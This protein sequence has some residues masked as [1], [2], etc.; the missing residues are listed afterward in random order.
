[1]TGTST[2]ST[3]T[4]PAGGRGR[5]LDCSPLDVA[6]VIPVVVV[7]D[8][9]RAV[10]LAKA[11]VAGGLPIIEV[12]L[13]SRAALEGVRAIAAE[14]PDIVLGVGT[15]VSTDQAEA[16]SAA[17]AQFLVSPGA[18]DR[19]LDAMTSTGVPFLAGTA[20]PSDVVRLLERG[21]TEAKLFPAEVVGGRS[22]LAALSGPFPQLRFC[23]TGGVT[24]DSA[25]DYLAMANVGCV[26]GTW[27]A[28]AG[29]QDA[30][31]WDA[32]T[33][34]ARRASELAAG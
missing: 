31:D 12:T 17:G 33:D 7:T 34:L 20:G 30:G 29:L 23:P 13:R 11:L 8:P 15:I 9:D 1:M 4:A 14:V 18:T 28:P 19:L 16:A 3:A 27:V 25:P 24:A 10:R 6:P 32:I 5:A 22:M 26:G 2:Q 21:I